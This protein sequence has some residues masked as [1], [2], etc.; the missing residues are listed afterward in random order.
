[1]TIIREDEK[2]S[3]C[4]D[5]DKFQFSGLHDVKNIGT[6]FYTRDSSGCTALL[7][8]MSL[9]LEYLTYLNRK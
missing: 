7:S 6:W 4:L 3:P 8:N 5:K 2:W 1:M 9:V